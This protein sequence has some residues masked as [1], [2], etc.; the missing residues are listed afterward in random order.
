M[1]WEKTVQTAHDTFSIVLEVA[2]DSPV[3]VDAVTEKVG[4]LADTELVRLRVT[5]AGDAPF[6]IERLALH[7]TLPA[8]DMHGMYFGG[9]PRDELGYLPFH[10][11]DKVVAAHT[12][13][14]YIALVHRDGANRA[15]YGLLGQLTETVL[16]S[17]LSE[18]TRCFHLCI[19][20]PAGPPDS[21][22]RIRAQGTWE[23]T[24]FVSRAADQ[25]PRVL[26]CYAALVAAASPA[27]M[28]VPASAYA[29]VFCTW[30]AIHHDVSH[31]WIMRNAA[32]AADL[33]F[34]TWLTDDGWFLASGE[35][36]DYYQVGE[37]LPHAAKFPDFATHVAAVQALGFRYVVWVAPF[38]IGT[39]SAKAAEYA[40]L[41]T[42]GQERERF[43]NLSPWRT[44]TASIVR[45]LLRRLVADY[46][47]DGLKIDFIDAVTVNSQRRP[48]EIEDTLGSRMAAIL[49]EAIDGV[50]RLRPDALIEFRNRYANL[51]SRACANIYRCSDV[52]L[53][54][55]LNRWQ[56]VMLRLLAPD[57][58]VHT[59]PM[60]W[61][62]DDTDEN[63]AV[64]LING[65][66]AVPMVSIDLAQY[67]QR[68]LEII[69]YWIGFYNKHRATIIGG[70]LRPMLRGAHVPRIDFVGTDEIIT[71]LYDDV[72]V[73][74]H[75]EDKTQWV[76]NAST[77]PFVDFDIP[78]PHACRV[79]ARDKMGRTLY[80]AEFSPLP[81]RL[82][83][84]IGGS[85]EIHPLR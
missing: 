10:T 7:W 45:N 62:P 15:A 70:E 23:E 52:P 46:N 60:L 53:N 44:E 13:L 14:P 61:H 51:F 35:F 66:A 83:V 4:Q 48:G 19:E 55:T 25:W 49:Q 82:T 57:R 11:Q 31:D 26:R 16:H 28:P 84:E 80:T 42:T 63:V 73:R 81:A 43:L 21:G 54:I 36:G 27:P 75:A 20:Q 50:R 40:G 33:G 79:T 58:A 85:L 77:Q 38:M 24:L 5:A 30:T 65:I 2:S 59:D 34:G 39:G 68:H 29:P 67:P 71:G 37:W 76:L 64:H 69:R 17:E 22:R 47:L 78:L 74:L 8:V 56:A 41:L 12:G 3:T 72:A 32:I 1:R 6:F 18:I 9:D